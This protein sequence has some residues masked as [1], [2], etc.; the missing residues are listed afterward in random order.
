MRAWSS[1][2]LST[3]AGALAYI[4]RNAGPLGVGRSSSAAHKGV[5]MP[6]SVAAVLALFTVLLFIW[7]SRVWRTWRHRAQR[8]G[9]RS[10][11]EY[12][13]AIPRSDEEK[14][15]AVD[16]ALKGGLLCIVGFVLPPLLL[17]GIFPL[18]Y[19][20][21]KIM[22]WRTGLGLFEGDSSSGA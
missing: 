14:K 4:R 3:N 10:I 2:P 12:L 1:Y 5:I 21:R 16:L 17:I 22:Y 7:V 6:I 8:S 19:G 11:A 13:R 18:Y 15:E 9:Y 20:A